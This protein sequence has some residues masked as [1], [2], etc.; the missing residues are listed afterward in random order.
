MRITWFRLLLAALCVGGFFFP[1]LVQG[2][3]G[4]LLF[5]IVFGPARVRV[6]KVTP[7]E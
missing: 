3:G 7:S 4:V 6:K 1:I 5:W 2:L